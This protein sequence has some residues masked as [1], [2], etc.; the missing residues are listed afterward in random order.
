MLQHSF[1][2][3]VL[4]NTRETIP[5]AIARVTYMHEHGTDRHGCVD[6]DTDS[7]ELLNVFIC[8]NIFAVQ[9]NLSPHLEMTCTLKC[10]LDENNNN[11]FIFMIRLTGDTRIIFTNKVI[12]PAVIILPTDLHRTL[13]QRIT[14]Y[15]Q[16]NDERH[17]T[18]SPI[19][20][21]GCVARVQISAAPPL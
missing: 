12:T 9:R 18:M 10:G 5:D 8:D 4:S 19:T 2:S 17:P 15:V 16:E 6:C 3:N 21:S 1:L 20:V 13:L 14:Q 11:L 7:V